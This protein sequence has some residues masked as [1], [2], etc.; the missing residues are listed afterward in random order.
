MGV[1]GVKG[2][3]QIW[4]L[5]S[6]VWRINSPA[7]GFSLR[8]TALGHIPPSIPT[9]DLQHLFAGGISD[10][11]PGAVFPPEFSFSPFTGNALL[12]RSAK[13]APPWVGPFGNT[14]ASDRPFRSARGLRQAAISPKLSPIF[15]TAEGS[16]DR[17][18]GVPPPGAYEFVSLPF[19]SSAPT[20]LAIEAA[21]GVLFSYMEGTAHW[22]AIEHEKGGILA[23]TGIDRTDWRCEAVTDGFTSRVFLSTSSG[24]A[25]LVPDVPGAV[26]SVTY[27]GEAEAVGAPIQFGDYIW[28][29]VVTPQGLRFVSMTLAGAPGPVLDLTTHC[30]DIGRIHA[31]ITDS[32]SAIWLSESGQILLRKLPTGELTALCYPWPNKVTPAF[33]FGSPYLSREGNLWQLCFDEVANTYAYLQLGVEDIP[34]QHTDAPRLCTGT[35][36]YRF[37]NKF[38]NDPWI[39]PEF[40]VDGSKVVIPILESTDNELV[41]GLRLETTAGLADV[42][43]SE[44]PLRAVLQVDEASN[45][46]DF[47]TF[48]VAKPW[49]VRFFV[50]GGTLWLYH[51]QLRQIVGW[52]LQS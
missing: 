23:E 31:P 35:I 46:V 6:G 50:H 12:T 9:S 7:E 20:L 36:N 10:S 47:Y 52:D 2:D 13:A 34:R 41:F 27:T 32:R 37:A 15:R 44:D 16:A 26:F 51:T 38:K 29:P 11:Q 18:I 25:C 17:S 39:E 1:E 30:P 33:D 43:N 8:L 40:G 5:K 21:K 48:A 45:V 4:P 42:L 19:G 3:D 22:Q 14:P 28:A 49:N 24:L